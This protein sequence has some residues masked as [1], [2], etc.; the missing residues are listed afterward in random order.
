[1]NILFS[2]EGS[3]QVSPT[4]AEKRDEIAQRLTSYWADLVQQ[5]DAAL[6]FRKIKNKGVEMGI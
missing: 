6:D 2:A 1:M 3:P 4:S 5:P